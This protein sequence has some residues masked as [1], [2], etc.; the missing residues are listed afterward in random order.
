MDRASSDTV[1]TNF[2]GYVTISFFKDK[3]CVLQEWKS[4]CNIDEYKA[5][6][7]LTLD[8]IKERKL[9]RFICDTTNASPLPQEA[10]L[11]AAEILIPQLIGCGIE[12][13]DLVLPK[14]AFTKLTID[15]FENESHGFFRY[16]KGMDDAVAT[17]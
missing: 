17:L 5:A 1:R 8:L 16:H 12:Y 15:Y 13:V 3:G 10:T 7:L 6:Q 2:L 14:S 9:K 11:W 4:Y